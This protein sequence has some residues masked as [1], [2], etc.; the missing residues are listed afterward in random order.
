MPAA[1]AGP[2]SPEHP[3][4][5]PLPTTVA[6]TGGATCRLRLGS[7]NDRGT[8]PGRDKAHPDGHIRHHAPTQR[9]QASASVADCPSLCTGTATVSP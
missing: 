5:N 9:S 4:P 2:P 6:M 3:V 8:D 7:R 1:A